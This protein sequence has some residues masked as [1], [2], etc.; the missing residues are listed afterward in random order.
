MVKLKFYRDEWFPFFGLLSNQE[1]E[2]TGDCE[3]EMTEE[4]AEW[5][6]AI[7]DEIEE[8]QEFLYNKYEEKKKNGRS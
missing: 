4:D 2:Y 6:K 5:V 3:L 7:L 8:V 1:S